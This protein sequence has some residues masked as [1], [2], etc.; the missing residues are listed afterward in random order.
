[1]FWEKAL[2]NQRLLAA[3]VLISLLALLE[4]DLLRNRQKVLRELCR[5]R[6][7]WLLQLGRQVFFLNFD[8][9]LLDRFNLYWGP[10]CLL[11]L[12]LSLAIDES[13]QALEVALVTGLGRFEHLNFIRNDRHVRV[14][15]PHRLDWRKLLTVDERHELAPLDVSLLTLARVVRVLQNDLLI[16]RLS[17]SLA[18]ELGLRLGV[19]AEGLLLLPRGALTPRQ[20]IGRLVVKLCDRSCK[21]DLIQVQL[22]DSW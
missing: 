13:F 9:F 11:V 8:V 15:T 5:L 3:L 2:I 6:L 19:V 18:G 12:D 14:G 21:V 4:L 17:L 10:G 16:R 7:R 22:R 20:H 1:M